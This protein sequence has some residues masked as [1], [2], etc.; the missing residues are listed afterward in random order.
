M[1]TRKKATRKKVQRRKA[2]R[3]GTK[4]VAEKPATESNGSS[5]PSDQ[6]VPVAEAVMKELD[7]VKEFTQSKTGVALI[8]DG[9]KLATL[10][11]SRKS[12]MLYSRFWKESDK[13]VKILKFGEKYLPLRDATEAQITKAVEKLVK[14]T[15]KE[16][17]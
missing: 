8:A 16:A 4:K 1:T 11:G 9:K 15:G 14:R 17:S 6:L 2:A 10:Y 12:L 5:R 3:K 7:Q 13:D